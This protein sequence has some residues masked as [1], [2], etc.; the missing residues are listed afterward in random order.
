MALQTCSGRALEITYAYALRA[1]PRAVGL[2]Q[3]AGPHQL[4]V[5]VPRNSLHFHLQYCPRAGS[6]DQ[7]S[8]MPLTHALRR[9]LQRCLL[10]LPLHRK[11]GRFGTVPSEGG[12]PSPDAEPMAALCEPR[13]ANLTLCLPRLPSPR[14]RLRA[15]RPTDYV[16]E[17]QL[18][19][20]F[21]QAALPSAGHLALHPASCALLPS[22][23]SVRLGWP[24][25]LQAARRLLHMASASGSWMATPAFGRG[26]DAWHVRVSALE[27]WLASSVPSVAPDLPPLLPVSPLQISAVDRCGRLKP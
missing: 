20:A 23:C 21:M 1:R 18:L 24:E 4:I 17:W 5:V 10:C 15:L 14:T 13:L 25:M 8:F 12:A 22:T 26:Q 7:V 19:T 9:S 2:E 11:S 16:A 6:M 3:W 27:M